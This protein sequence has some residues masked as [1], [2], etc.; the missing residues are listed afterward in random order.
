ML[1]IV[2]NKEVA[3]RGVRFVARVEL[4]IDL[5]FREL[6][7][8]HDDIGA[9]GLDNLSIGS[10]LSWVIALPGLAVGLEERSTASS[11]SWLV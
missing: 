9:D 4:L 1:S 8:G 2:G 3:G 5:D 10:A 7:F 6:L 11:N